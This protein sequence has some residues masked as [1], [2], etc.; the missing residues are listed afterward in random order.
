MKIL[1]AL[2]LGVGIDKGISTIRELTAEELLFV[3]GGEDQG[4]G[5]GGGGEGGGG[6]GGCTGGEGC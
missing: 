1:D 2:N 5:G 3:A 6:G 4:G